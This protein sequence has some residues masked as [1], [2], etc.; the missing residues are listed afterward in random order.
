MNPKP[1]WIT[2]LFILP[3]LALTALYVA[4]YN[5]GY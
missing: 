1:I 2:L 5:A 3:F 4:S